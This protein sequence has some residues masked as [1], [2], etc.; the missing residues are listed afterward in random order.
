MPFLV[1]LIPAMHAHTRHSLVVLP[2]MHDVTDRFFK[3]TVL[4][5]LPVPSH[6]C[7]H[8]LTALLT[9]H[10]CPAMH[11]AVM[12]ALTYTNFYVP[13]I[14]AFSLACASAREHLASRVLPM[15]ET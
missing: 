3:D 12:Y 4:A 1:S 5:N 14:L 15:H 7:S 13:H 2:H 11:A 10:L 8:L 9:A 6:R